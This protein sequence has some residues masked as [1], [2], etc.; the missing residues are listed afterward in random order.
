M[1]VPAS[2]LALGALM[3]WG[4]VW[5]QARAELGATAGSAA[6]YA[7]RVLDGH[8][9]LV[10]RVDE[11]LRGLSDDQIRE[12]EPELHR[13][14]SQLSASRPIIQS[15]YALD[16]QGRLLVASSVF[17]VPRDVSAHDR[18]FF[19][20]LRHADA[21]GAS[22]SK[23]YRGRLDGEL[24]F[25]VAERRGAA[26][27]GSMPPPP[28]GSPFLGVILVS[29]RPGDVALGLQRIADRSDQ[30]VALIRMDGEVLA[31]S[32]GFEDPPPP[33][34][35]DSPLRSVMATGADR[36]LAEGQTGID[37]SERLMAFRRVAGWPIF[38]AV[39]Q[40]REAVVARW[41][42]V[43]FWQ[44][45]FGVPAMLTLVGLVILTV[46]RTRQVTEARVALRSEAE[47]RATADALRDT[48]STLDLGAFMEG[49]LD[50]TIRYWSA[51]CERLF[52]WT[53]DD[54]V[55]RGYHAL[56]RTVFPVP[57]PEIEA[58]LARH[59]EW[60]GEVRHRIRSGQEVVVATRKALRR[61]AEGWPASIVEA[62]VDV[63]PLW[64]TRAELLDRSARLQT[65]SEAAGS[66]LA[67]SD[68]DQVL[69][70]LFHSLSE[71]LGVDLSFSYLVDEAA[72][73]ELQL[74]AMFGL[75]DAARPEIE[76]L[77]FGAAVCGVVAQTRSPLYLEGVQAS[78]DPMLDLVR[79]LGVRAYVA[80]PL[81]V[82]ERL[83][84]T[85]SF[86][87]RQHDR[88]SNEDL[89]LL[90]TIAQHMAVLRERF[91][92]ERA[93]RE[94]E[95]QLRSILDTVPDAMIIIDEHGSITSFSSAAERLF[96]WPARET[97][98]R[99]VSMLMPSPDRER[100]DGYIAHYLRTGERRIIGTGRV[101]T[102]LRRNGSTFPMELTVGE[103]S[104]T[105][106]RLFTG[107]V[108]DLTERQESERRLQELQSE[109]LHVSRVSA[110]GEMASALAHELNQPLTAIA[111]SVKAALRMAQAAPAGANSGPALPE[112]A[113]EAME[114]AVGQSLRAGQIVRRLREFVAK[115]EADRQLE[116]L[117][118]LIEEASALGLVGARQRGVQVTFNLPRDLP[119]VLVDRIQIQQVLLNLM[120]NAVEAMTE[121]EG[122]ERRELVV[123]A[124]PRGAEEV[125]LAVAD[126]GPG[127]SPHVAARLF[128]PF[129]STKPSGMGVGLSICRSI[130][131]AHGGRLWA[132]PNP[133]GG[134]V[135]RL[136]LPAA[137][138]DEAML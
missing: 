94:A 116:T 123:A 40:T 133:G 84:G 80:F 27:L 112:R 53:A 132:E 43:L 20:Q 117:P 75:P 121:E 50:G 138:P 9:L 70:T 79:G 54:A 51:G 100:H 82:G 35:L 56:L 45:G 67:S 108:R 13:A 30:T 17:P 136:T 91:R 103:V 130:V 89:A 93:L 110:A 2:I 36:A 107:F 119:P 104:S 124:V 22:V 129:V 14:L 31:R 47:R 88:F 3:A 34:P 26:V 55:G 92:A 105:G 63:T 59:G 131:E 37:G 127:L 65:L 64:R 32:S 46:R 135:F 98:G 57:L 12:R 86:G 114:R 122:S 96:G 4:Q 61:N 15:L 60:T 73:D 18:D 102:G 21:P 58:A 19:G 76:R 83:I 62:M 28:E 111:S 125:E 74:V 8:A 85:L 87:T 106:R 118:S 44:A 29:L 33:V 95:Q 72:G 68:P 25:A 39:T 16:T 101:V 1:L 97:V 90:G 128:E 38:T 69:A 41:R 134:T 24:F 78:D 48:L 6:E 109:L 71:R 49:D 5:E 42:R 7:A 11:L 137:A 81:A 10:D 66:L 120:R 113:V 77:R 52:G 23:V 115:G 126:T 99:N